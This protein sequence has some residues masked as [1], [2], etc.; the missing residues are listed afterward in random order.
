ME[1]LIGEGRENHSTRL[2][3]SSSSQ[4]SSYEPSK[5]LNFMSEGA[6]RRRVP[7]PAG[8]RSRQDP[9]NPASS[10][11][12]SRRS[13]PPRRS[14]SKRPRPVKVLKRCSSEPL[15]SDDCGAG[16]SPAAGDP[17]Q[18]VVGLDPGVH[19]WPQTCTDIFASSPSLMVS[20]SS[21][22]SAVVNIA[23]FLEVARD[24]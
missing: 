7:A 11:S 16:G 17:N 5:I 3:I 21:P 18:S 8:R 9:P 10:P 13:T 23:Q 19:F 14:S 6:H 4:K 2:T 15:L 22:L 20:G 24:Q 1:Q 12:P